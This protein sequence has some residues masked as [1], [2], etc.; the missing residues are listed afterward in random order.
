MWSYLVCS[1]HAA[2]ISAWQHAG[3]IRLLFCIIRMGYALKSCMLVGI[4]VPL[5]WRM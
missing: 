1:E 4:P 3:V 2:E 5:K